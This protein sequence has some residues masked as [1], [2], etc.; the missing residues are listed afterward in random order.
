M[1]KLHV[2]SPHVFCRI[3]SL[4]KF[5]HKPIDCFRKHLA[6]SAQVPLYSC[7]PAWVEFHFQMSWLGFNSSVPRNIRWWSHTSVYSIRDLGYFRNSVRSTERRL[8]KARWRI[9]STQ[10]SQILNQRLIRNSRYTQSGFFTDLILRHTV[11]RFEI[12]WNLK[13]SLFRCLYKKVRA[14]ILD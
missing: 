6:L 3:C 13:F 12:L 9:K 8:S 2:R 5:V 10:P 1:H 4:R 14:K 7:L 11:S